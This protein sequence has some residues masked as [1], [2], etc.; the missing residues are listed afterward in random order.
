MKLPDYLILTLNSHRLVSLDKKDD[1]YGLKYQDSLELHDASLPLHHHVH[2]S[3]TK[4]D[5][6]SKSN[7]TI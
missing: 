7:S 6:H 1:V 2:K 5:N 4:K 3:K